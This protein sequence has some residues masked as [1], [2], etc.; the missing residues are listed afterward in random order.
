MRRKVFL[1]ALA[2]AVLVGGLGI[3]LL[4]GN[5]MW[6]QGPPL[7]NLPDVIHYQGK[8]VDPGTGDPVS[9]Q[10]QFVFSIYDADPGGN[11][12][13]QE[14]QNVSVQDGWFSV[15]LGVQTAL[16]DSIFDGNPR[17]LGIKVGAD[18]EMTPRQPLA[19]VPYAFRAKNAETLDGMDS[20]DFVAV[21]GDTMTGTLNLPSN[22]LVAG[23]DQLVLSG[24][25]VGIGTTSP[26]SSYKLYVVGGS[27][28][29]IYGEGLSYGVYG[30]GITGVYGSGSNQGVFGSS[31]GG[32][33]VR[34]YSSG[35][36]GVRGHGNIYDFYATGPGTNYGP[37]TGGHEVKLCADFPESVEPGMIV[38]VTGEV[39]VRLTD[40]EMSYSSTLPTVQ[41]SDTP[42]D[43]KVIGVII[44]EA[45][46]PE[47]HWYIDE[48]NEGDRFGI[49]NALGEGRVWVTNINGDIE[50]GDYI[51]TSAIAGYGQKQDDDLLH[52]YTLGKAIEDVDWSE[53]TETVEFDGYTYK[54]YPISVVYTSG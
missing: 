15:M 28:N 2:L 39:Q 7:A 51:T 8:L 52:S 54:A 45:P 53:V 38:S 13:W 26:S 22:G 19:T 32:A 36:T 27:A 10:H 21:A 34:G 37:F 43:S 4:A 12:L 44:A 18:P 46:L 1:S 24:G 48:A 29:A 14:T 47:E 9:G 41:L 16:S 30:S 23:G 50:D 33:G 35:G 17:Y 42:A 31:S 11:L 3:G 40:G 6:A 49:I 25:N 20:G 5:V